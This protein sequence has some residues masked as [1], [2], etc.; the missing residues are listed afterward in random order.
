MNI[1]MSVLDFIRNIGPQA[2]MPIFMIIIG[3]IVRVPFGKLIRA[4]LTVAIGF[5][6]MNLMIG[7]L[8]GSLAGPAQ[9]MADNFGLTLETLDVGWAAIAG[10]S[11][12]SILVPVVFLMTLGINFGMIALGWTR[13]INVDVWN[14]HVYMFAAQIVLLQTQN[15]VLALLAAAITIVTSLLIADWAY[16]LTEHIFPGISFPHAFTVYW[17]PLGML[18]NKLYDRIPGFRDIKADPDSIREKLGFM[19]EPAILGFILGIL[20]G[21]LSKVDF[22]EIVTLGLSMAAVMILLPRMVS[23]LMEGI[24]TIASGVSEFAQSSKLLKGKPILIGA[25]GGLLMSRP[26][27]L[28][29][30]VLMIPITLIISFILPGNRVL[31]LGELAVLGGVWQWSVITAK[32]N[33]I[34]GLMT[35][36]VC[37]IGTLLVATSLAP[38]VTE[39]AVSTGYVLPE[40]V[41]SII[42]LANGNFLVPWAF[43]KITALLGF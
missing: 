26:S 28:A 17:I 31:P 30:A 3:L 4:A 32:E 42:G 13:T 25:D 9:S 2:I 20:I 19:G 39:M 16:P 6:G 35:A 33:V 22:T 21:I 38:I 29:M 37:C 34:R 7:L 27:V 23:L 1:L 11:W 36:I 43:W 41:S 24:S 40:G 18:M 15:V 12:A 14:Y 10:F 5:I 8:A